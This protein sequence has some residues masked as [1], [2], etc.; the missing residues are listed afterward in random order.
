MGN[1]VQSLDRALDMLEL[2]AWAEHGGELGATD[3]ARR[4]DVHKS[5][6]SRLLA[7][8][9]A[10][11]LVEQSRTTEKYRLG[12]ALVRLGD[13]AAGRDRLPG[14]AAPCSGSW[15]SGRARP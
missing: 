8:L 10:H 14:A 2:L 1:R 9:Q 3:L 5:T 15:P 6:A 7:T 4:L 12:A 13:I 11:G